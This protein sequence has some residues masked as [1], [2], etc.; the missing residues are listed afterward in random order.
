MDARPSSPFAE[1]VSRAVINF[2]RSSF[3]CMTIEIVRLDANA[4]Y[5]GLL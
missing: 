5:L 3:S 2:L 1:D 4:R